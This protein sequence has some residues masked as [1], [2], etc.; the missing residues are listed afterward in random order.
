MQDMN[1]HVNILVV[2]D[3]TIFRGGL[4]IL[5]EEEP[6]FRVVGEASSESEGLRLATHL[7]PDILLLGLSSPTLPG[8]EI[9]QQLSALG[10]SVRTVI[11]APA[12]DN[13]QL[14]EAIRNGARGVLLKN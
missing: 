2:D 9:L 8:D 4:K 7:I 12:M 5:L 14:W 6:H 13:E 1:G 10:H 11:M 3:H